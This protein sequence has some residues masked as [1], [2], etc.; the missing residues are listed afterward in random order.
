MGSGKTTL[1]KP[2][3]AALGLPFYDLDWYIES[4]MHATIAELFARDG[5]AGFRDTERRMLHEVA[6]FENVVIAC[7]GGTPCFYDNM[8]YLNRQGHTIY[9]RATPETLA[10]HLRMGRSVRPLIQGKSPEELD[11][12]IRRQLALREP[13]YMKAKT[14]FDVATLDTRSRIHEATRLLTSIIS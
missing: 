3:A 6:E 5:E 11:T 1:G 4:R 12:F 9:L 2:L 7:G 14:I 13:Y 10:V 8:D